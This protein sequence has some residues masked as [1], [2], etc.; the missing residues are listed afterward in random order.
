LYPSSF[1]IVKRFLKNFIKFLIN[2][3]QSAHNVLVVY[4]VLAARIR[5]LRSKDQDW[6][7]MAEFWRENGAKR[8]DLSK[9]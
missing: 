9:A 7:N 8:N 1:N 5:A 2:L 3:V 6:Q 4:E